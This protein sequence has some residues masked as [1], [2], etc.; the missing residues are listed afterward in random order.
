M[1]IEIR[2]AEL[3]NILHQRLA[4]GKFADV[5]ELLL[6][7]FRHQCVPPEVAEKERLDRAAGAAERLR[8]LRR[9]VTLDRPAGISLRE[10]AHLGHRY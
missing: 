3:E 6:E 2:N 4:G 10:Y 9:G 7:T 5:E 8:E 1:T